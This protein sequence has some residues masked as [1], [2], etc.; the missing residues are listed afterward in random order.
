MWKNSVV[1]I[2][3]ILALFCVF[4][5]FNG[6]A[7]EN[8]ADAAMERINIAAVGD[9]MMG[10]TYPANFLPPDD[11]KDLFTGVIEPL[12]SGDIVFGNLEGPLTDN[13]IPTKCRIKSLKCFEFVTPTRYATHLKNSGFTI[14]N[15]ANNHAYDCGREG[16]ETTVD[17][18]RS[19]GIEAA[20]GV[21]IAR[22]VVKGRKIAV[23]GFS[24]TSSEHAHSIHDIDTA[25]TI[26]SDLKR[27]ND[28]VIISFHGGGEGNLASRLPSG[29]EIFLG[30]NRGNVVQFS[31]AVVDAGADLVL[32]HGPHVLRAMELY[33]D[34]LIVYSLGNFAVY[35]LFNVKVLTG[36]SAIINIQVSAQNGSFVSGRI[37]PLKLNQSGVPQMDPSGEAIQLVRRLSKED[38]KNSALVIEEDGFLRPVSAVMPQTV[39]T[40]KQIVVH[41]GVH[42]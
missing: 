40:S 34:R 12:K 1:L 42:E 7:L 3:G 29:N 9:I 33:K 13:G 17:V 25:R 16:A 36:I 28:I 30:E 10:S 26:V 35:G 23:A 22:M 27:D 32:G 37:S 4:P 18:L 41:G 11:G 5:H 8:T 24:F 31:R 6:F 21:H 19:Y 15:V 20:G 2:T 14:M 38:V 39:P